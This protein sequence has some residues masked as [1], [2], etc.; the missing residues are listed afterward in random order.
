MQIAT[1]G[2]LYLILV[3]RVFTV[4]LLGVDAAD[5]L[6]IGDFRGQFYPAE[7]AHPIGLDV[8]L[9]LEELARPASVR[10]CAGADG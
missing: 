7:A 4:F 9:A 3:A 2:V 6:L 5:G 10:F 1:I 8:V